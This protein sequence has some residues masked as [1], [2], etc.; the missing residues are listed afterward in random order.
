MDTVDSMEI[1]N[2]EKLRHPSGAPGSLP[3][4]EEEL[5]KTQREEKHIEDEVE[6]ERRRGNH[7][8]RV[9]RTLSGVLGLPST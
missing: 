4:E 7:R 5:Y 6:G 9:H 8:S 3:Q 1:H 2:Q